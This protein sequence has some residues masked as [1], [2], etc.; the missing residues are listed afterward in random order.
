M[1]NNNEIIIIA[2]RQ[3]VCAGDDIDSKLRKFEVP[4]EFILRELADFILEKYDFPNVS[5][6]HVWFPGIIGNTTVFVVHQYRTRKYFIWKS[7][8][9]IEYLISAETKVS[10]FVEDG[11]I[12]IYF[13]Y[14]H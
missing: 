7:N 11:F 2:D 14:K 10:N 1:M 9:K 8:S 12:K 4:N 6:E 3:A 5:A 13:A